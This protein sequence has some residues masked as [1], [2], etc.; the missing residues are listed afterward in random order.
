MKNV[1]EIRVA[2]GVGLEAGAKITE[3]GKLG[4]DD[5]GHVFAVITAASPAVKDAKETF[6]ELAASTNAEMDASD[7]IIGSQI[8]SFGAE[9]KRDIEKIENGVFAVLRIIARSK[10]EGIEEGRAQ[11]A[12]ELKAG[13]V[14]LKNL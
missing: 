8:S 9:S 7:A 11:L 3:D 12:A 13:K 2:L 14:S 1:N 6:P 4:V 5:F 10:K